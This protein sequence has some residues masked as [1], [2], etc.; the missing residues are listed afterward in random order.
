MRQLFVLGF[1]GI[2]LALSVGAARGANTVF[3]T[4]QPVPNAAELQ[5]RFETAVGQV[6]PIIATKVTPTFSKL[7]SLNIPQIDN[8]DLQVLGEALK[9]AAFLQQN[10]SSEDASAPSGLAPASGTPGTGQWTLQR[11]WTL[12]PRHHHRHCCDCCWVCEDVWVCVPLAP[13]PS[14]RAPGGR[15]PLRDNIQE[16]S[17]FILD[18]LSGNKG[19]DARADRLAALQILSVLMNLDP[20]FRAGEVP[21]ATGVFSP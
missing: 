15:R 1:V 14:S 16:L 7:S 13:A 6:K 3:I 9:A 20:V 19:P 10:L 4:L 5:R 2:G 8:A 12:R 18:R 21:S 17:E 11:Q